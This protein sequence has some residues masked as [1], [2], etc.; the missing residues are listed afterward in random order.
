MT[1]VSRR[2]VGLLG[3]CRRPGDTRVGALVLPVLA[4]LADLV[5]ERLAAL[6][7]LI[8]LLIELAGQLLAIL[9]FAH[10]AEITARVRLQTPARPPPWL[11]SVTERKGTEPVT[12][13]T[14]LGGTMT[15]EVEELDRV[16]IRFAGDSGDGMQLDRES[17]HRRDRRRRQRPGDAAELPGRDPGAG[18]HAGGS[19]GVP[20]P[21]RVAGHPDPRRPSERA[22]GDEPGRAE[23]QTA[24]SSSEGPRSSSTRTRSRSATSRRPATTPTRSR[25]GRS[26]A[27][28]VHRIPMSTLTARAVEA[29][30]GVSTR[31]AS[32]AKNLFALGVRLVAVRTAHRRDQDLDRAEV[33]AHPRGRPG[34]PGGVQR[35]LVVRRDDGAAGRAVPGATRHRRPAR[36]V[37]QRQRDHGAVAGADRRQRAQ[38]A[39]AGPRELSDHPRL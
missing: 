8:G 31:D 32:R 23:G 28:R 14:H 38:R 6:L 25:T 22:G 5:V 20:D 37:P 24:P 12:R 17:L 21:L 2:P 34:Q 39:A 33:R 27:Y 10:A 29:I 18:G 16:I 36:H 7:E 9:A 15:K 35:R 13:T 19:L 11:E 26:S 1:L 4:D 3:R 30:E